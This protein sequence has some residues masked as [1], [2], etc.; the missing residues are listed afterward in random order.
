MVMIEGGGVDEIFN[1]VKSNKKALR[2]FIQE[3]LIH[4]WQVLMSI[5]EVGYLPV[6]FP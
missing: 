4:F 1:F 2:I 3:L 6:R 5:Q